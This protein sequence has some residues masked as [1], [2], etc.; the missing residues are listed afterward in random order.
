[1]P[2]VS[3][4]TCSPLPI[5]ER[6]DCVGRRFAGHGCYVPTVGL[7]LLPT[8]QNVPAYTSVGFFEHAFDACAQFVWTKNGRNDAPFTAGPS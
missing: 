1:M 8:D 7:V 5:A 2:L 6:A 4:S 3:R